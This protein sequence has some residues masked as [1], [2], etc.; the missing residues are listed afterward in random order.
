MTGKVS[1]ISLPSI[2]SHNGPLRVYH[3]DTLTL[4]HRQVQANNNHQQTLWRCQRRKVQTRW[5]LRDIGKSSKYKGDYRIRAWKESSTYSGGKPSVTWEAITIT[6]GKRAIARNKSRRRIG[7]WLEARLMYDPVPSDCC[8]ASFANLQHYPCCCVL[9]LFFNLSTSLS[10]HVR[11]N[12][13]L[14]AALQYPRPSFSLP[15]SPEQLTF[16]SC[17]SYLFPKYGQGDLR[18]ER[19]D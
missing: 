4:K 7:I 8:F 6:P 17:Q 16:H 10:L 9:T 11:H 12:E 5:L 3:V 1:H 14:R 13:L 2:S 18:L 19:S 15:Y